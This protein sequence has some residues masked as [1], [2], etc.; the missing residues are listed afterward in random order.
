MPKE[1][2]IFCAAGML[3]SD[4]KHDFVRTYPI[5]L[6]DLDWARFRTAYAEMKAEGDALLTEEGIPE[7]RVSLP[8]E[9]R[10]ALHPPV[11]RGGR[12]HLLGRD[13]GRR[14]LGGRR[15]LPCRPRR[16]VRLLPGRH[17][18]PGRA[19]QLAPDRHRRDREAQP[20]ARDLCGR[21]PRRG[22]QGHAFGL[23]AVGQGLRRGARST[24]ASPSSSATRSPD[25]ASSSR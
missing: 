23:P 2:S 18:R 1:S 14:R 15:P 3:R 13:R 21:R 6:G 4:L 7:D 20:A 17:R 24:T 9:P 10:P 22:L 11:P 16:A 25:P 5:T 8:P 19:D 12:R